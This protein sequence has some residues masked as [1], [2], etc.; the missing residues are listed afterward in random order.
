MRYLKIISVVLLLAA[1]VQLHA[2]DAGNDRFAVI[3]L[4]PTLKDGR[5]WFAQWDKERTVKQSGTDPA[6]P[7]FVNSDGTLQIK[8]GV[9]SI[10]AGITRLRV[11]SPKDKEGK[12]SGPLWTNVEM[13]VY[14][15]RG[16]IAKKLNYQSF[17]LSVRSGEKHSDTK[18]CDGTSYHAT[19]RF[20]GKFGFKKEIWHSGGYTDLRPL[21]TPK[22]V[23]TIPEDKW[24]GLKFVCRNVDGGKHV[25]LELYLD[26]EEKNEWKLVSEYTDKGGWKGEEVGCDRPQDYIITEGRPTVYFRTDEVDVEVKKFSVREIA[27]LP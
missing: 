24:I 23:K 3:M 21:P 22:P 25:K 18:P 17:C 7:L 9:A 16:P 15:K 13:T 11:F 5:E 19:A 20:D 1:C 4:H 27:P 6:D 10:K 26:A 2:A 14:A 12:Y 8:D